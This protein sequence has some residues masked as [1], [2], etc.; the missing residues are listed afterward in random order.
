MVYGKG[1]RR[2]GD[3]PDDVDVIY[4]ERKLPESIGIFRR[5][6]NLQNVI[7]EKREHRARITLERRQ[8]IQTSCS[9]RFHSFGS[10]GPCTEST[11]PSCF[12]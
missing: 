3:E 12:I 8:E 7:H 1:R 4:G 2:A 10:R 6:T 9:D 11:A 5:R